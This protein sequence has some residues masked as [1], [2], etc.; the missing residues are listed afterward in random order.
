MTLNLH[1]ENSEKIYVFITSWFLKQVNSTRESFK[2]RKNVEMQRQ[3]S[4]M[5]IQLVVVKQHMVKCDRKISKQLMIQFYGAILLPMQYFK[6]TYD[7]KGKRKNYISIMKYFHINVMDHSIYGLKKER[8][9]QKHNGS[10]RLRS[11]MDTSI[12]STYYR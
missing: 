4:D 12:K 6:T 8:Q 5:L 2:C 10:R 11:S 7:K 9:R 1:N 3:S